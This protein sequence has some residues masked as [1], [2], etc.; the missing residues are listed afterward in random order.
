MFSSWDAASFHCIH[1]MDCI[2]SCMEKKKIMK[3]GRLSNASRF[4]PTPLW[5]IPSFSSH[6][7]REMLSFCFCLP[8][9]VHGIALSPL[10]L[11]IYKSCSPV[12]WRPVC[13]LATVLTSRL[14]G[15]SS[16]RCGLHFLTF[17]GMLGGLINVCSTH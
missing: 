7:P 17:W 11:G 13:P 6:K 4:L 5:L 2:S 1:K 15:T 12:F 16:V 8:A 3:Q 14:L 10:P 9:K